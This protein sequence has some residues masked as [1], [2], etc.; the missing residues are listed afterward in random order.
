MKCGKHAA[1]NPKFKKDGIIQTTSLV[2]I[3]RLKDPHTWLRV[4]ITVEKNNNPTHATVYKTEPI[5]TG[6]GH[7]KLSR[8][9][10]SWLFF[11]KMYTNV[12]QIYMNTFLYPN[13]IEAKVAHRYQINWQ[14]YVIIASCARW[15]CA[16][17]KYLIC[18]I[19]LKCVCIKYLA[20][21]TKIAACFV[22]CTIT[23]LS[24]R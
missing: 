20:H 3:N 19:I 17:T 1:H 24:R 4:A 21:N 5:F 12:S 15:V 14:N 23:I 7:D 10:S 11:I 16:I 2:A 9:T 22:T 8:C 13:L 18:K 6:L